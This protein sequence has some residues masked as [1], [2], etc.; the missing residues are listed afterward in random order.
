[1]PT[2]IR[3]KMNKSPMNLK[4]KKKNQHPAVQDTPQTVPQVLRRSLRL[5]AK[6]KQP[7]KLLEK[8]KKTTLRRSKRLAAKR[9]AAKRLAAKNGKR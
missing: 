1:M 7:P 2:G 3:N 8:K 4:N 5:M 6:S 9:L